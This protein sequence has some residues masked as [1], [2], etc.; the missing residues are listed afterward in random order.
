ME[1]YYE[2]SKKFVR[3]N[4]SDFLTQDMSGNSPPL[5]QKRK[6]CL[7]LSPLSFLSKDRKEK[8]LL[9]QISTSKS[10][11]LSDDLP[12]LELLPEDEK[13]SNEDDIVEM[14]NSPPTP[15]RHVVEDYRNALAVVGSSNTRA[16][17]FKHSTKVSKRSISP[18]ESQPSAL[19]PHDYEDWLVEDEDFTK[20]QPSK[21]FRSNLSVPKVQSK[22]TFFKTSSKTRKTKQKPQSQS[23]K[24]FVTTKISEFMIPSPDSSPRRDDCDSDN[25]IKSDR[26]ATAKPASSLNTTIST[27]RD[28][29]KQSFCV[30]LKINGAM[31][32]TAVPDAR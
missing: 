28:D 27:H 19:V 5:R 10:D 22:L 24:R 3:E 4:P 23:H 12:D 21:R 20:A 29:V 17:L 2:K 32:L 8:D 6:S 1:E 30:K 15:S 26:T 11:D 18:K 31:F 7:R 16:K 25:S 14:S 13:L 9:S